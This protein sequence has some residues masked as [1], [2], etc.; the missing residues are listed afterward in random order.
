M[1]G[2]HGGK[3]PGAGRPKKIRTSSATSDKAPIYETAEDYLRA[4]VAGTIAPDAVRVQAAKCLIAYETAKQRAPQRSLSPTKMAEREV[5][6]IEKAVSSEFER[7]SAEIRERH[8]R[9][10]NNVES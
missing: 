5:M 9:R 7:K 3:R 1:T 6:A 8:S 2:P 10:K 4:V